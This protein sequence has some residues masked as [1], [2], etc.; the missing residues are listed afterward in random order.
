M[1][2]V[3]TWL[4]E[5]GLGQYADAFEAND[6]EMDLLNGVDD[7]MLKDIGVTSAGH[8]L[9]I[10]NA[11]ARLTRA[12]DIR[13]GSEEA[14]FGLQMPRRNRRPVMAGFRFERGSVGRR[15]TSPG[16]VWRG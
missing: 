2:E 9:R 14:V 6:V 4:A 8:R 11:I 15:P 7:Q 10:R 1:S 3:R 13:R 16:Q 5:I 12:S